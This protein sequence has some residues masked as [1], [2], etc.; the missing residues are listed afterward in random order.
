MCCIQCTQKSITL[1]T[2]VNSIS[3]PTP[4]FENHWIRIY[5]SRLF[6]RIAQN[7]AKNSEI[8]K[9][10]DIPKNRTQVQEICN[11]WDE[12]FDVKHIIMSPKHSPERI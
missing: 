8:R 12:R 4:T 7:Q 11:S 5:Y 9:I 6:A 3:F 2:A 10:S 1:F